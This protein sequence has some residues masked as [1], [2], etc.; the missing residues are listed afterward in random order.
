MRIRPAFSGAEIF[1]V[2][3]SLA[4]VAISVLGNRTQ[5]RLLAASVWPYISLG[6]YD[7][8]EDGSKVLGFTLTNSGN[9]PALIQDFSLQYDHRTYYSA[10]TLLTDCCE[11]RR[12]SLRTNTVVGLVLRPGDTVAYLR[13]PFS[14]EIADGWNKLDHARRDKLRMRVCYCSTLNDCFEATTENNRPKPVEACGS[15]PQNEQWAS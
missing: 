8:T 1:A 5:E 3:L 14:E 4:S 9:G 10:L 6:N 2:L 7:A 12:V 11:L 13:L 15:P